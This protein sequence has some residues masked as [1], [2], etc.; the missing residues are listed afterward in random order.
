MKIGKISETVLKRS[1]LKQLT[2]RRE[3]VRLG[4]V[5]GEDCAV[6]EFENKEQMLFS[7]QSAEDGGKE[8]SVGSRKA[9]KAGCWKGAGTGAGRDAALY[10]IHR[11][12]NNIAAAGG[13]PVAV[14]LSLLLPASFEERELKAMMAQAEAVCASLNVQIAGGHTTVTDAVNRPVAT[15]AAVGKAASRRSILTGSACPGADL[16]LTKWV[17]L[18]GTAM[19]AKEKEAELLKRFP[20][21]LVEEAKGFDRYLS[22]LPEAGIVSAAEAVSSAGMADAAGNVREGKAADAAGSVRKAK[23]A[24]VA[25]AAGT[26]PPAF[27]VQAM[28]DVSEGGIFAALWKLAE[29]SH[30][31]L[32]VE[33]KKLPIRQE[34]VEICNFLDLNPYGLASSGSLLIAAEDGAELARLFERNG[35]PACVVGRTTQGNDRIIRNGEE[36]RF[37]EPGKPDERYRIAHAAAGTALAAGGKQEQKEG[38]E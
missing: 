38:A 28:T 31:G 26:Y 3:E 8:A 27:R 6:L 25:Q 24:D 9:P 10:G 35:I 4:A 11:A 16:V 36:I 14:L 1:V 37:L 34:T 22:I 17:A 13:E 32:E 33:L 20:A 15:V 23:A 30:V 2:D 18:E 12:L 21:Y 5:P 19:A 7:A 29:A